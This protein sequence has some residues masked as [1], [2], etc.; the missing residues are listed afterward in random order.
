V[1]NRDFKGVRNVKIKYRI[2]FFILGVIVIGSL[3]IS[4]AAIK[5]LWLMR[6]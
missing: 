2:E 3:L 4:Y 6:S 1:N 5:A